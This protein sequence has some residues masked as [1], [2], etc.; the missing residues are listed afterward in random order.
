MASKYKNYH[1]RHARGGRFKS[2]NIGDLG[3]SALRER[4]QTIIDSLQLARNQQAEIDQSQMTA[5]ERSFDKE[6]QNIQDLQSLEDK[7]YRNKREAIQVR[8]Q[9]D[10]EALKG[11]ADEYRRT[12]EYWDCLLYTYQSPRDGLQARM[13]STARKK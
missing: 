3:I 6:R 7:I 5:I 4:D 10:I 9:R 8:N 2:H 13:P 12:A 11:R 1:K